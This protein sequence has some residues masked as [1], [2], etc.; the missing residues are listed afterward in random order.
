[1]NG[2]TCPECDG[3]GRRTLSYAGAEDAGEVECGNCHGRGELPPC[4]G[5]G[6]PLHTSKGLRDPDQWTCSNYGCEVG[7]VDDE[8]V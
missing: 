5:C 1:M 8:E 3:D 4:P 6:D 2:K 7:F